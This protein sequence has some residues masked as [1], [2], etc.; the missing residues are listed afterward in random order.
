MYKECGGR[1]FGT[2]G[3]QRTIYARS[4]ADEASVCMGSRGLYDR[5]VV[6]VTSVGIESIG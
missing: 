1:S 5:C 2:K 6:G 4:A 3:K